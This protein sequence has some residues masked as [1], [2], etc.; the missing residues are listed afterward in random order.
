MGEPLLIVFETL[1]QLVRQSANSGETINQIGDKLRVVGTAATTADNVKPR[2]ETVDEHQ[3]ID[4]AHQ[5]AT[6]K[7]PD[8]HADE[9]LVDVH[10]NQV[11]IVDTGATPEG[12]VP[13]VCAAAELPQPLAQLATMG[14][15]VTLPAIRD[16]VAANDGDILTIVLALI[17]RD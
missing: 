4:G 9:L 6:H 1:E 5:P 11:P 12:G 17:D 3:E 15:D 16:V 10:V 14:F 13:M 2:V 7:S 8:E